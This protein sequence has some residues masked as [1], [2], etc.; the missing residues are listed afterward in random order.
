MGLGGRKLASSYHTHG[1]GAELPEGRG[2]L[3]LAGMANA[4]SEV[5]GAFPG[6]LHKLFVGADLVKE[7]HQALGFGQETAVEVRFEI[8]KSIVDAE[9]VVAEAARKQVKVLLLAGEAFE[10]L[11]KLGGGRIEGVIEL[12]LVF[13]GTL[14]PG[15]GLFAKIRDLTVHIKVE[16]L[17]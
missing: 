11:Q 17:E 6:N 1:A 9:T 14:F 13:F 15:K 7:R 5:P 12:H 8:E 16:V 4:V 2:G 10:D 3:S